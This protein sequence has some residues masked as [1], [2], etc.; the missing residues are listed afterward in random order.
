MEYT[1]KSATFT[2]NYIDL[3]MLLTTGLSYVSKKKWSDHMRK[4][5]VIWICEK[6]DE[7]IHDLID[8]IAVEELGCEVVNLNP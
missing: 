7:D 5:T 8:I 6:P 1:E 3:D 4:L 2:G